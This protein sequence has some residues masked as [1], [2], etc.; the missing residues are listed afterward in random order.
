MSHHAQPILY[1]VETGF[2]LHVGQTGLELPTLG[3][4]PA[5]A[6]HSARSTGV[7]LRAQPCSLFSLEKYCVT[8]T[9]EKCTK[10][11]GPGECVIVSRLCAVASEEEMNWDRP[12]IHC[13]HFLGT[14]PSSSLEEPS[15]QLPWLSFLASLDT[16]QLTCAS[17]N[18]PVVHVWSVT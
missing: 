1:L 3:D 8:Y 17:L 16:F 5:L 13:V 15:P 4:P 14:A 2:S 12:R 6:S 18:T 11:T 7:S 9:I 10:Q